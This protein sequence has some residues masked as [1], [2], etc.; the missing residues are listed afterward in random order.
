M[1]KP[2]L[3]YLP[4]ILAEAANMPSA[5]RFRQQFAPFFDVYSDQDLASLRDELCWLWKGDEAMSGEVSSV[6]SASTRHQFRELSA[7]VRQDVSLEEFIVGR[8]LRRS[9]GGGL[10][11]WWERGKPKI[12]PDP[13]EL[14]A[15]LAWGVLLY[16]SHL[17]ICGNPECPARYF[18]ADRRDQKYCS[19]TCAAPAKREAKLRWWDHHKHVLLHKRKQQRKE[20]QANRRTKR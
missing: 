8:W 4:R 19:D 15:V 7:D 10:Q 5:K 9:P 14:P 6:E 17:R 13:Y 18:V 1:L 3:H 16:Y 2:L 20:S 12:Y 11:M